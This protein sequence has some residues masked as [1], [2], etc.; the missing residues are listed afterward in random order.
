MSS[1]AVVILNYNRAD[2][3]ADCLKSIYSAPTRC[4]LTV[5]VV[6]NAST[7]GSAEMVQTRF[8]QAQLIVSPVNGGFAYGNNLALRAI[9]AGPRVSYVLLL[10]NDT[11]VPPGALDGL[12][13]Y[14]ERHPDVGVVGPKL[15]LPDGS[16][17]LPAGAA[18]PAPKSRSIAWRGWRGSFRATRASPATT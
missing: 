7:D 8:P 14:L 3:L 11:V 6:D 2:L 4:A 9:L 18:F 17:D 16:L 13:E 12:V 15:L 10:N 1:L 5:W